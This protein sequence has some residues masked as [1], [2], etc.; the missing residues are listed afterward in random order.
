MPD[1]AASVIQPRRAGLLPV[2]AREM[3]LFARSPFMLLFVFILP[4]ASFAILISVFY[5]ETPR[6]LPIV[7]CD[8]DNSALSRRLVR[9]VDASP[10]LGVAERV[11]DV[12]EGAACIRQGKAYALAYIPKDFERDAL[13]GD[14]PAVTMYF[15][16]QWMLTSGVISRGVREAIGYLSAGAD[17][18]RRMAQ[19]APPAQALRQFEPIRVDAH[20]LFNPGMNYR[21]FLLPALFPTLVQIFVLMVAVRAVGSELRHGT[22]GQ[23]LAAAG[24]RVWVALLGKLFPYTAAYMVLCVFMWSLLVR[25]CNVPLT[26]NA[27]LLLAGTLVFILAYQSVG[28]LF[29]ALTGN[30]RM[31]SSISGFYSGPAFAFAGV[32]FPTLGMPLPALI[33]SNCLPLSH[34]LH[35]VTQ[36]MLQGAPEQVSGAPLLA[37]MAFC[38]LPPLFFM[39]RLGRMLRDPLCWGRI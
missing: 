16:N 17:V 29:V 35:L 36:Q 9:M 28:C 4:L 6:D 34:Y 10:S 33:W 15:N 1:P 8:R 26:G 37:L 11:H 19:G 38:L 32:T 23:W 2:I 12:D 22:A 30:L 27:M 5:Q 18:R 20:V 3:G 14:A 13:R 24:D 25:F 21:F 31:A 39:P 7:V